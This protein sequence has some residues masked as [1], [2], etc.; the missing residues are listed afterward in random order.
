MQNDR[1]VI[2]QA[3]D[4]EISA[5]ARWGIGIIL[6]LFIQTAGAIWWASDISSRVYQN[7]VEITQLRNGASVILTR[8][9]LN[10]ILGIRDTRLDNIESSIK[11]MEDKIDRI[12]P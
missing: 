10:D 11:R 5:T 1:D 12:V 9:Q 2:N 4:R 3:T 6:A 8:E 7:E